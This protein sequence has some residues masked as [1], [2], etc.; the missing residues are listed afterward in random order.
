MHFF[1]VF[2]S[3]YTFLILLLTILLFSFVGSLF[4]RSVLFDSFHL[5]QIKRVI[6]MPFNIIIFTL[7][8]TRPHNLYV[9]NFSYF[10][11]GFVT[12]D[13]SLCVQCCMFI[14]Y[15]YIYLFIFT[16]QANVTETHNNKKR[17]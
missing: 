3:F 7:V 14:A 15:I 13:I 6:L 2:L 11:S 8:S 17:E 1:A 4:L 16:Y 12:I 9:Y 10:F 5:I